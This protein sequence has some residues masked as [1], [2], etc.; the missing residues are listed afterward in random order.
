MVCI[1]VVKKVSESRNMLNVVLATKTQM[2]RSY[3]LRHDGILEEW[4]G[5]QQEELD[6][7][8]CST[9]WL[10]RRTT[11]LWRGSLKIDNVARN[12]Q[13]RDV[14]EDLLHNWQKNTYQQL[15]GSFCQA[16]TVRDSSQ[17]TPE[18]L[19]RLQTVHLQCRQ[20]SL[21]S[22]VLAKASDRIVPCPH[23]STPPISHEVIK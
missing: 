17:W 10:I 13:K 5:N 2:D 8:S 20:A 9:I 23:I 1:F 22:S 12:K 3:M 21:L 7:Y 16:S 6:E 18:P 14:K 15:W 11:L 4:P 19:Q